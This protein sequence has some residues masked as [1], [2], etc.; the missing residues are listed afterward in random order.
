MKIGITGC[1]GR[2]GRLLVEEV[3]SGNWTGVSLSGGSIRDMSKMPEGADYFIT[4]NAAELFER[5]D[6]VIDFTAPDSTAEH[7]QLAAAHSVIFIAAT[8]GLDDTHEKA[9][10]EAAEKVPVIYAANT[11]IGVNLLMALVEQA[12][13]RLDPAH[14]DAEILDIHH[15]YKIDAPS[16][17]SY[18]LARAIKDGR[19]TVQDNDS[20]LTFERQ[21]HTG[22][23][24]TGSIGFSVQRGGDST[25]EN[26]VVFFGNG[27]RLE[28]THRALDRS[29]FAKGAIQA[30]LWAEGQKPGLYTM[31]DVLKI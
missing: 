19:G 26:S 30:A 23:R 31:R 11:S 21:G 29:I 8:S 17:T 18:A 3:L 14:W 16:G 27:E 28:L 1:T 12:A 10:A 2:I 24:E 20:T 5:S 9:L 6:A 13:A 15:R 4:D 25:I 7:A 22:P